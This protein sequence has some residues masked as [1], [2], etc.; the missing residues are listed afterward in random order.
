M[1][2]FRKILFVLFV[3]LCPII[4]A[5]C[6]PLIIGGAAGAATM[7]YVGGE[8]QSSENAP[9]DKTWNATQQAAANMGFIVTEREKDA[10]QARMVARTSDNKDVTI[11]LER[12]AKEITNV[13]V[14]VGTFGDEQRSRAIM[15]EI[16]SRV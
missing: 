3:L 16:R 10:T 15:E 4:T 12:E 14:R 7:A 1:L 5:G 2:N 6:A 8:L 11:R 13:R 9:I